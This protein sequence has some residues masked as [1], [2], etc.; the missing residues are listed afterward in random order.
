VYFGRLYD[1]VSVTSLQTASEGTASSPAQVTYLF[2]FRA[3]VCKDD[4]LN[5]RRTAHILTPSSGK[6]VGNGTP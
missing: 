4:G 6:V 3:L 5:C 2:I 1:Q